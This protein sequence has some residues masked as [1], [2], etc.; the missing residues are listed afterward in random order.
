MAQLLKYPRRNRFD[1]HPYSVEWNWVWNRNA[2]WL[3]WVPIPTISL[4]TAVIAEAPVTLSGNDVSVPIPTVSV[5]LTV[6]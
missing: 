3:R 4:E 5:A 1:R 2:G 6:A